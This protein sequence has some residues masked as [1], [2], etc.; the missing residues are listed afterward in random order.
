MLIL[1]PEA[2]TPS[3]VNTAPSKEAPEESV[4]NKDTFPSFAFLTMYFPPIFTI[5]VPSVSDT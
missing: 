4:F 3:S 1:S 5:S 2:L